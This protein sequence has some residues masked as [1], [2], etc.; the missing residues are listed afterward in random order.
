LAFDAPVVDEIRPV[1]N[2]KGFPDI[3]VG[4]QD[5]QTRLSQ[6]GYV[7]LNLGYRYRIDSAERLVQHNELGVRNQRARYG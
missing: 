4:N 7:L 1:D 5:G 6:V 3:V 2:L